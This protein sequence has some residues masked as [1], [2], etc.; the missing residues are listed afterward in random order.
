MCVD[1][2]SFGSCTLASA[3]PSPCY[4]PVL[5]RC[6]LAV[7]SA[8]ISGHGLMCDD[9]L[10]HLHRHSVA[11]DLRDRSLRLHARCVHVSFWVVSYA[12]A[13]CAVVINVVVMRHPNHA[14]NEMVKTP[15]TRSLLVLGLVLGLSARLCR[16]ILAFVGLRKL[17]RQHASRPLSPKLVGCAT[18]A[19]TFE[20]PGCSAAAGRGTYATGRVPFESLSRR[21]VGPFRGAGQKKEHTYRCSEDSDRAPRGLRRVAVRPRRPQVEHAAAALR[22]GGLCLHFLAGLTRPHPESDHHRRGAPL[23]P[24]SVANGLH[25]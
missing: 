6:S 20:R 22:A 18:P 21:S 14:R 16:S 13:A 2:L 12:M 25:S 17:C 15:K 9:G 1:L 11:G 8:G 3:L 19:K 23:R 7:D 24:P 4:M 10:V 5:L